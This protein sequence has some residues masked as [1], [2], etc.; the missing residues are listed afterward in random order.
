MANICCPDYTFEAEDKKDIQKLY[1]ILTKAK[2]ENF[3]LSYEQ[4]AEAF[5]FDANEAAVDCCGEVC[6][7]GKLSK[8]DGEYSFTVEC[9][10]N[11]SP[12]EEFWLALLEHLGLNESVDMSCTVSY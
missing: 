5:D 1:D 11:Y 2:K 3:W 6:S 4:V 7:V 9:E 8:S 12:Q 10:D